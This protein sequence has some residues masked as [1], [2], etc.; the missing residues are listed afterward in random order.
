V[1]QGWDNYFFML[2]SAGAGLIGLL[3]VVVTLTAGFDREQALRGQALYMFPTMV[4]FALVLGMSAIVIAPGL[5]PAVVIG[6]LGAGALGGCAA[7]IRATI[8]ILRPRQGRP[9]PHWSDAWMYG[10]TPLGLF[11]ILL[12]ADAALAAGARWAAPAFALGELALLLVSIRNA[13]DLIT[14]IA[15]SRGEGPP[16]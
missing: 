15:P 14:A 3:F 8:G 1:F 16:G 7:A 12:I 2:G 9:S 13:W 5:P 6:V 11:A 4:A 10:A